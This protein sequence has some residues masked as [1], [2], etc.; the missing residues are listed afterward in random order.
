MREPTI[1]SDEQG[2][3]LSWE[4][5]VARYL[6]EHADFFERHPE[7]LARLKLAH[8]GGA[9]TVSLIE[10]QVQVL[11]V[12]EQDAERRLRELVTIAREN[13]VLGSRLHRLAMA[14]IETPTRDEALDAAIELLRAEFRLEAVAV[15]VGAEA[16]LAGS[17]PEYVAAD[18]RRMTA[19]LTLLNA[20]RPLCAARGE[21]PDG[22]ARGARHD[23]ASDG[24]LLAFVF[25]GAADEI[26]S[27]AF[28]PLIDRGPRGV[29]A[30]GSRDPLRFHAGMG[31]A[32]LT[33]LGE[34]LS[35]AL[36]RRAS[37]P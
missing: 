22:A 20:G 31:T 13:D 17:R 29:L 33:R 21:A 16:P 8:D 6:D 12:R 7:T 27:S 37:E 36:A 19:L 34:L 24:A 11:R 9:R 25:G 18:D 14:L 32:Y 5:A 3:E 15:R 10:R 4:E 30:L 23:L 35:A 2:T 28:V 26:R 1:T